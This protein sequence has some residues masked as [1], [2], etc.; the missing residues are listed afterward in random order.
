MAT[1]GTKA[2][3]KRAQVARPRGVWPTLKAKEHRV[4]IDTPFSSDQRLGKR[5]KKKGGGEGPPIAIG[6]FFCC[7]SNHNS[8]GGSIVVCHSRL[9]DKPG[10]VACLSVSHLD[11]TNERKATHTTLDRLLL[12]TVGGGRPDER[13]R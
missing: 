4:H 5:T 13:L 6:F 11:P 12:R 2:G 7:C 1:E 3:H 8:R 9:Y 10:K